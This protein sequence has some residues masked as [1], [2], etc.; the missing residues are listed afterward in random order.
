MGARFGLR[1]AAAHP[2]RVAAL[3]GFHAGGLATD[4]PDSPHR[5]AGDVAA[6]LYL[7]HADQDPSM[8]AEQIATLD[9]ALDEAGVRHR[10]EVYAGAS[11]GYT[12][13][14]T[15]AYDEAATERHFR[16]LLA[17]LERTIG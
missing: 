2:D 14:D 4:A 13:S 3:G 11:H 17:L 9:E 12:M 15:A 6:E 10:T 16:E 8:S 5:F 7:G 1:I